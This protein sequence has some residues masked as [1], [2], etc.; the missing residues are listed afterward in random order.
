MKPF[1][2]IDLVVRKA[3]Y[4]RIAI[5]MESDQFKVV[6]FSLVGSTYAVDLM[7]AASETAIEILRTKQA[8]DEEYL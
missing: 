1:D 6:R 3:G 7:R 5:P 4:F 8:P 2:D